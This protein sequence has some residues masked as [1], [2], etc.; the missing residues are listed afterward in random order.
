MMEMKMTAMLDVD[1]CRNMQDA[2]SEVQMDD[3]DLR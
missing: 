1:T 2:T 3:D